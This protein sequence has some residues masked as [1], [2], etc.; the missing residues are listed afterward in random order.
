MNNLKEMP[1]LPSKQKKT[2]H[3]KA[4]FNRL[5]KP[6]NWRHHSSFMN[7]TNLKQNLYKN[8][9]RNKPLAISDGF[10]EKNGCFSSW[11]TGF[12]PMVGCLNDWVFSK[13]T[14]QNP[15]LSVASLGPWLQC[16]F[17]KFD[18]QTPFFEAWKSSF[19]SKSK[20]CPLIIPTGH[21]Y[22]WPKA[23]ELV[24]ISNTFQDLQILFIW[25]LLRQGSWYYQPELHALFFGEIFQDCNTYASSLFP[26]K[27]AHFL[28]LT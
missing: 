9:Y 8:S 12:T 26:A 11:P 28:K 19:S 13:K 6:R 18:T 17:T 20:A 10:S 5:N 16:S 4:F 3:V 25:C 24:W 1:C 27:W 22:W 7:P 2:Y 21:F 23:F 14:S 15:W